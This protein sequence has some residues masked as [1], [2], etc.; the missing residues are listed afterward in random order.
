MVQLPTYR[1]SSGRL[2]IAV[3][4]ISML[5]VYS[6]CTLDS[7]RTSD[8]GSLVAEAFTEAPLWDDGQAEISFYELE[9]TRNTSGQEPTGTERITVGSYLV[10]HDFNISGMTK[11]AEA[12]EGIPAFKYAFFY[13]FE[14]GSYQF[15][16]SYVI[17]AARAGLR[18]LKASFTS[19]DWCSN[20]YH[21]LA[22]HASG[23]IDALFRSDD[24]GNR[25]GVIRNRNRVF[26][27]A[28]IPLLIRGLDFTDGADQSFLVVLEDGRFVQATARLEGSEAFA[29]P[30][31]PTEAERILVRYG[32]PVPSPLSGQD[33]SAE[34]YWRATGADRLLLAIAA[35]DG[36]YRMTLIETLRSPYWQE[37]I[38]PLLTRVQERP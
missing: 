21:E 1:A 23:R 20:R 12:G 18:P 5:L 32:T 9:R 16:H 6:A 29:W 4:L 3:S 25:E 31:G 34:R 10:K 24:Y 28:E 15:K 8:V 17:N 33:V 26:P 38:F 27:M 37:D 2:C 30:D 11:A 22:F 19:F 13:E 36:S 7:E 35:E 14:R